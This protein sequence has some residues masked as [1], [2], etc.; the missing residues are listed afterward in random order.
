MPETRLLKL[1]CV[2]GENTGEASVESRIV[3][4]K[5]AK[6]IADIQ[7]RLIDLSAD[8]LDGQV[9]VQGTLHKQIFFVGEDDRVHH[10]AEDVPFAVFVDVPGA[11]AGMGARVQGRI[12]KLSHS[13]VDMQELTQRAILQFFVK[14]TEDCQVNVVL[15][16]AGPLCK[17]EL[18]VGEATQVVPVENVVTLEREA[19]K[20]R[21]VRVSLESITAEVSD[22]Q[23]I[24]QGTLDKQ[25]F[26]I[27]TNNEEFHQE[28]K[29]PFTGAVVIPGARPGH[30]VQIRP[31]LIR[32]DRFLT[33]A[34]QV[35]QR[36]I[37]SVFVKVTETI[38]VNVAEDITG[39]LAVCRRVVASGTRQVLVES[40]VE[41]SI[42]AQKVHEIQARL[43]DLT[44]EVISNKVIVQGNLH[45]QIFFVGSDDIVHHQAEEIPFTTF[46]EV[47][48]AQPGMTCTVSGMVEHI[49]WHLIDPATSE[50]GLRFGDREDE[51][52]VFCKLAEK[53]VI[54]IVASVSE[55]QQI[56]VRT[57]PMQTTLPQFTL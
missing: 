33:S 53:T 43:A 52:P 1:E 10:Q 57:V 5:R 55:D 7:A 49:S 8:V 13:L 28:E 46:V 34:T 32:V 42:A 51:V 50:R 39:P 17:A 30:N 9:M 44:C 20:I 26:Y 54:Q 11:Q 14:V 6:K 35:R 47:P 37:L 40:V 36:V 4:N 19:I 31:Q 16:P 29:V 2:V 56:H 25:I 48:G 18:V 21:D 27:A 38:D 45:K 3:L 12:A 41:L 22:D 23:V 15:D 24:F